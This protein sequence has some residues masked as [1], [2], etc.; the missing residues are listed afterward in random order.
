MEAARS[1]RVRVAKAAG[2]GMGQYV[3]I[4]KKKMR[5]AKGAEQNFSIEIF[6]VTKIIDRR[7]RV[8]YELEDLNGTQIDGQIYREELT[9][10]RITER[11][12]YKIDEILDKRVTNVI[13]EYFVSRRA[14]S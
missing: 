10:V 8:A 9:P 5:F 12:S 7:P 2:F 4:S 14:Y 6:R 11:T 1:E 3:S 13:R